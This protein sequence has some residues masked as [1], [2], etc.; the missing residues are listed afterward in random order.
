MNTLLVYL[1]ESAISMAVLYSIYWLFLR[2]ETF[3]RINRFYLLSMICFSFLLPLVPLHM[4]VS[5]PSSTMVILLKPVIITPSKIEQVM[6]TGVNW[7]G[8]A[9]LIYALGAL[10]FFIRFLHRLV[11][12]HQ[13]ARNFGIS[14]RQ[15]R[16]VVLVDHAYSPF[17]FFN[18]IFL[19]ESVLQQ[20]RFSAILEHELIHV[21]QFHTLDML[22]VEL[23]SVMQ[24]FNPV[25]WFTRREI[26]SIHE[27]LAD[28][29]VLQNG[30]SRPI[31]QQ[32]ILDETMGIRVN[33]LTNNFNVSLLKK[34]IAMMTKS[35]SKTW[36]KAKVL[37]ALPALL[38]LMVIMTAGSYSTAD[39][40]NV[41]RPGFSPVHLLSAPAPVLQHQQK[42]ETQV[43]F[44]APVVRKD[45]FTVVE[46]Q[47][48]FTGGQEGYTRF[49]LENIKY[50]EDAIK[51]AVT[52]TVY[53]TFII[54]KDG[55]VTEVKVLR[56]IGSGCD[57]EALRVVKMMP[58][59]NPGKQKG[60]PVAV[61]FNLPIKF[62]LDSHKKEEPKK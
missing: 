33:S 20:G 13:I 47:P 15:G 27:Y 42:K 1:A 29:G 60:E 57:E 21:R 2:K 41:A 35:K 40:L 62:K 22:L 56:G 11:Q 19:N 16:Q 23:A 8:I 14:E 39:V 10:F 55:S 53:I 43:K 46:Q 37:L 59:W 3:F 6:Q 58:K 36:A 5:N 31:Y 18:L 7:V 30:I 44:V 54:E 32:L 51:K 48:S 45:V 12:L 49:L 61:Q 9:M 38:S 50:P 25:M 34:R 4:I 52:G 24:W 28:E 26:K 17:S